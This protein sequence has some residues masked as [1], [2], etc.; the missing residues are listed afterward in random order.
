MQ[1]LHTLHNATS[2]QSSLHGPNFS[3]ENLSH[4]AAAA[5]SLSGVPYTTLNSFSN[6]VNM[7]RLKSS[8]GG[9]QTSLR[10]DPITTFNRKRAL[11]SSPY[12]DLLDVSSMIR[13]SPNSLY[14][15]KNSHISGSFGHLA[16]TALNNTTASGTNGSLG[17][18]MSISSLPT[19]LQHFLMSGD[20]LPSLSGH[21]I[22]PTNSMFSLAHHQ[23]MMQ[24]DASMQSLKSET[25]DAQQ[26]QHSN[27]TSSNSL[28]K[29][30]NKKSDSNTMTVTSAE[31]DSP[32]Q[33]QSQIRKVKIKSENISNDDFIQNA[34]LSTTNSHLNQHHQ[35]HHHHH[36]HHNIT[37]ANVNELQSNFSSNQRLKPNGIMS[38]VGGNHKS[39]EMFNAKNNNHNSNNNNNNLRSSN[40]NSSTSSETVLADTTDAKEDGG[41]FIETNCHWRGCGLE[42]MTQEELVRHINTDH[43]HGNKKSFVCRW[44]TCSRD[45]KPFKAQYML[46]VHMRRHTGEKPHSCTF[47]GCHKAYSRLENLK[48]HLRSHTGEK[49]YTCEFPG[50]SKAFS[51]AS[52]RAKHQN[53]THSNEK[54][55]VCKAP[56][57]TKR[58]TDPS[59]LRKHVKTVHGADFYA[60][61]KHK[62]TGDSGS[63]EDGNGVSSPATNEDNYSIKTTSL[64]SPSI[65]S[66]S[67]IN[68][69]GYPQMNSPSGVSHMNSDMNDDFD[70]GNGGSNNGNNNMSNA[71]STQIGIVSSTVDSQ[72]PYEEEEET[73]EVS[74]LPMV[75]RAMIDFDQTGGGGV[76]LM[77]PVDQFSSRF[78]SRLHPKGGMLQPPSPNPSEYISSSSPRS[79]YGIG[80]LNRRITD[81]KVDHPAL[82]PPHNFMRDSSPKLL[83]LGQNYQNNVNTA[84]YQQ[85]TLQF[86][87]QLNQQI[88]RD[89]N[90]STTSSSYYSM[91]SCDV[92]RRSSNQSHTSSISTLRPSSN[93]SLAAPGGVVGANFNGNNNYDSNLFYDPI[94]AGSSRRSSQLSTADGIGNNNYGPPSSQL[95]SSHLARLQ[96]HSNAPSHQYNSTASFYQHSHPYNSYNYPVSSQGVGNM[97]NSMFYNYPTHPNAHN[98]PH[99]YANNNTRQHHQIPSSS[100]DRRMSEPISSIAS[101]NVQNDFTCPIVQRPRSTTPT[102]SLEMVLDSPK[103]M[104]ST[105][106]ATPEKKKVEKES[107]NSSGSKK[108]K[109]N[110][111]DSPSKPHP[112]ETVVLDVLKTNEKIENC[113]EL[114]IPDDMVLYLNQVSDEGTTPSTATKPSSV[115]KIKL[116]L[117]EIEPMSSSISIEKIKEEDLLTLLA[118]VDAKSNV[119]E[120]QCDMSNNN[121]DGSDRQTF[122]EA[123]VNDFEIN[124]NSQDECKV[125]SDTKTTRKEI[126]CKS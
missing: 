56:G 17:S 44:E 32:S 30:A 22:S 28:N 34:K 106:A 111:K 3:T 21:Y 20:I 11:S 93:A 79:T 33:M 40:N 13:N 4:A 99:M 25:H 38:N 91:K 10:A 89:S 68:S 115:P 69:P 72:W 102:K 65:K 55:Y 116:D 61:R 46:V 82:S 121:A 47:E 54:P 75:L 12:P 120:E 109:S 43:I 24:V 2:P 1:L 29:N 117:D 5:A 71:N 86:N 105:P 126:T 58:Y 14:G 27:S 95:L 57:C 7:E 110:N 94:S 8:N 78:R 118:E 63:G 74:E 18:P 35:P 76:A 114:V 60:K 83:E 90:N 42:F 39:K 36:H 73:A 123:T 77:N 9:T 50:C 98:F 108:N 85:T 64:M 70:Y 87:Q 84:H 107:S 31:A 96:R 37:S 92:S 48:T 100:T 67:D 104:K 101:R 81:L 49:P 51:N 19:S 80:E 113:D 122:N 66:E 59:S 112:N 41:N 23:A 15:S 62:G 119:N 124:N 125:D 97:N 26:K 88:R 45:E 53:R 52:D 16:V 103:D 6:D